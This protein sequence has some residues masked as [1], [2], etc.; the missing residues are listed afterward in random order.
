MR[1]SGPAIWGWVLIV[2]GILFL[3]DTL[4]YADFAKIAQTYWP[5]VLIA[6]GAG[7]L[8]KQR[9]GEKKSAP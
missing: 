3:L 6:V 8:L 4:G 1:T 2:L 9:R 5:I 7:M